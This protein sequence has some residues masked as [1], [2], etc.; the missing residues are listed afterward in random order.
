MV[1]GVVCLFDFFDE[2]VVEGFEMLGLYMWY[3]CFVESCE[4]FVVYVGVC[5][6][7]NF[8]LVDVYGED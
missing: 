6:F 1:Y 7:E 5:V 3:L 8:C 4:K 2:E